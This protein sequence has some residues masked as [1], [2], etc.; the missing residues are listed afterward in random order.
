MTW[1]FAGTSRSSYIC[2]LTDNYAILQVTYYSKFSYKIPEKLHATILCPMRD[3][4]RL[5]W[6]PLY[7]WL[8]DRNN[9]QNCLIKTLNFSVY[10]SKWIHT[11]EVIKVR[12]AKKESHMYGC[13]FKAKIYGF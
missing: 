7:F 4:Q 1:L 13:S 6:E 3:V 8:S 11:K 5:D 2:Q 10:N 9:I 12:N